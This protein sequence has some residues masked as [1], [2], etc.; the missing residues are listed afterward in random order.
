MLAKPPIQHLKLDPRSKEEW[1]GLLLCASNSFTRTRM[2]YLAS[3]FG[4]IHEISP[5]SSCVR[6]ARRLVLHKRK[7]AWTRAALA[8][9]W[10]HEWWKEAEMR[11]WKMIRLLGSPITAKYFAREASS[12]KNLAAR[13][14]YSPGHLS[15]TLSKKW[16]ETPSI[17]LRR[18]RMS[19]AAQRL[20]ETDINVAVLAQEL[21]YQSPSSFIRLFRQT[22]GLPPAKYRKAHRADV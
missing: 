5:V 1:S 6:L 22:H 14:G 4:A 18:E 11:H 16:G 20:V 15:G 9:E 2:E 19:L 10:F 8:F 13:L 17:L 7:D 12:L 21:G 3:R